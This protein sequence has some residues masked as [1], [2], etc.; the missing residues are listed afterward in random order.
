MRSDDDAIPRAEKAIQGPMRAFRSALATTVEELRGIVAA[1]HAAVSGDAEDERAELGP[2]ASGRIDAD[3][4]SAL[5]GASETLDDQSIGAIEAAHAV[6]A[7]S[8]R[9]GT[10]LARVD[11][12]AGE[13]VCAA[14]R[15]ATS[16]IGRTFGAARV[17]GLARSHRYVARDHARMLERFDHAS[18]NDAERALAPPLLVVADGADPQLEGLATYL[19][20]RQ[21]LV[22]VLRDPTPPAPLARFVTPGTFVLQTGDADLLDRFLAFDGPGVAALVPDG[23]ARFAHD[24]SLGARVWER[25]VV[26][27]LPDPATTRRVGSR[28]AWQQ[29]EDLRLLADLATP[30]PA[31]AAAPA[32]TPAAAAAPAAAEP[33]DRLATWL[34]RHAEL[35]TEPAG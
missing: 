11:V 7:E 2:F 29:A 10:D 15:R 30:P 34:L 27:H 23:A 1:H 21:K 24:P 25:L 28:S 3:R 13:D 16:E 12:R 5:L 9:R 14:V 22:L 6:L 19:D 4:F 18:W 32:P 8:S 35:E 31:G 26:E 33:I 17:A 20:G